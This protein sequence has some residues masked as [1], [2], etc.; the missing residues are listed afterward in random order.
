MKTVAAAG[1]IVLNEKNEILLMYRRS[2]WDLPEGHLDKNETFEECALREVKEETGLKK[3]SLVKYTGTTTHQYFDN[4]LGLEAIK[5]TRWFEMKTLSTERLSGQA[6]E[7]IEW[8]KWVSK[9]ELAH[10]LK[11]SYP[12]IIEILRYAELLRD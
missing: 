6:E 4:S 9:D 2:K 1:G 10:Y 8:I 5:E 12:N 11:N 3:L 7:S